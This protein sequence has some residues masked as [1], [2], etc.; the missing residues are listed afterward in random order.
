M[1]DFGASHSVLDYGIP[2]RARESPGNGLWGLQ[3][4]FMLSIYRRSGIL[5][6]MSRAVI[7]AVA[8]TVLSSVVA[9][10][11]D[12]DKERARPQTC[13]LQLLPGT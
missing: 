1:F 12:Q 7:V 8:F 9:P 4:L 5:I 10:A 13:R 3:V 11:Q 2:E 6:T